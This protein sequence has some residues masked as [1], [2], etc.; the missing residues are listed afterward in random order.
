M[1][2]D[3]TIYEGDVVLIQEEK[4]PRARWKMGVVEKLNKPNDNK[5]RGAI[6]R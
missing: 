4:M 3:Q 2:Y 5:V 1:S 6:V